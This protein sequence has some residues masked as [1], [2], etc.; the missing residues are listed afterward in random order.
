MP[1]NKKY[2]PNYKKLYPG[3][4]ISKR[5]LQTL[6]SSD[7]KREYMEYDLKHPRIRKN[8]SGEVVSI[9]PPREE[10]LERL[11]TDNKQFTVESNSAESTFFANELNDTLLRSLALLSSE[12]QELIDALFFKCMTERDYAKQIG[13]AQKNVNMRKKR[14]LKKLKEILKKFS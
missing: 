2:H 8:K 5:V 4:E 1:K 9:S 12:E 3:T 6:N 11:V 10:S 14:I 7:R 13:I